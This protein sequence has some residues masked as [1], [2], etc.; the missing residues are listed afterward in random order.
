MDSIYIIKLSA[1]ELQFSLITCTSALTLTSVLY[2]T[3]VH[4][5]CTE[6]IN[7]FKLGTKYSYTAREGSLSEFL[8]IL[9]KWPTF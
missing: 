7:L 2:E 9:R 8:T 5:F 6:W 4:I 1:L 3:L